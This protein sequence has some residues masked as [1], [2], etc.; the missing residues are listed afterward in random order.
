[1]QRITAFI[2]DRFSS[3]KPRKIHYPLGY[4]AALDGLRGVM[5]LGVIVA[6]INHTWLPGS[7][8]FM[9]AFFVMSAYLI[10]SILLKSYRNTGSLQFK[11]FYI[12]S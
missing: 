9:D 11:V 1:M 3:K 12:F 8:I 10:T 4:F 7:V 6:H 5:T 2:Q